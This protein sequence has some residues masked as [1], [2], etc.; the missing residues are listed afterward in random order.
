MQWINADGSFGRASRMRLS[1][2]QVR[3]L[4]LWMLKKCYQVSIKFHKEYKRH[5][6]EE[7]NIATI[8]YA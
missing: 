2:E 3:G 8:G 7:A 6:D 5:V 1:G 4:W